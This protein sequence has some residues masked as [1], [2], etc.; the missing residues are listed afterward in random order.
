M[1][2]ILKKLKGIDESI[3]LKDLLKKIG[4]GTTAN[5]ICM[6][7]RQEKDVEGRYISEF[8]EHFDDAEFSVTYENSFGLCLPYIIFAFKKCRDKK[9]G[10]D[11]IEI[12]MSKSSGLIKESKEFER[13][14]DYRFSK[15]KLGREGDSWIRTIE[16]FIGKEGVF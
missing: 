3:F 8:W 9:L 16:K 7:C 14:H 1:N 11:L 13:K 2:M 5:Q 10:K 15:E 12:E 4:P 6:F